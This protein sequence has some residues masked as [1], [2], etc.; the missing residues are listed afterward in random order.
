MIR[1]ELRSIQ[2]PTALDRQ[3]KPVKAIG[4]LGG[5]GLQATNDFGC[6]VLVM[7]NPSGGLK[8]RRQEGRYP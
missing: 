5:V 7:R 1:A 3:D 4:E 6:D 8:M 2:A